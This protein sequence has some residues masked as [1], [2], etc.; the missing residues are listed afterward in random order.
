[1]AAVF[2]SY[3]KSD[4]E[5]YTCGVIAVD[6]VQLSKA[7]LRDFT[8]L[9][10]VS[11]E[12]DLINRVVDIVVDLDPDALVGWDIQVGSWGYLNARGTT[13]GRVHRLSH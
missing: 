3:R 10:S 2:Y 13:Y 8:T 11:T 5:P 4:T 7:K 9:E 12:V 6:S 1:M